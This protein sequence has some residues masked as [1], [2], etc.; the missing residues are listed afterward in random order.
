[1]RQKE[2]KFLELEQANLQKEDRKVET[3]EYNSLVKMLIDQLHAQI[4][5][6]TDEV[7][8][9]RVESTK[10]SNQI[11]TLINITKINSDSHTNLCSENL[12]VQ[13]K[14]PVS[15]KKVIFCLSS[16]P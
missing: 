10:K 11:D 12:E 5:S 7:T 3:D 13:N 16:K 1:M 15:T 8:F 14:A 9:L 2:K 6:L 4:L